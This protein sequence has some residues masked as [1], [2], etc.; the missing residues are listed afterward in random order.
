MSLFF[1]ITQSLDGFVAGP[2]PSRE[3]PLGKGGEA[4]HEWAFRLNAWK[5]PHGRGSDGAADTPEDAMVR[6]SQARAGAVIMGRLMFSGGSGPWADD[7]NANGWWGGEPP[8]GKPVFVL[9]HHERAP[10][11]LGATTFEFVTDG[12]EAALDRATA[13]AGD[14]DVQVSGGASVGRQYLAAG[15]L[16]ELLIH[17]APNMLGGGTRLL[18]GETAQLEIAETLEGPL[19]THV[20]YRVVR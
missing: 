4:L 20:R 1:E 14:K 10:L 6:G 2:A 16:D 19:A 8:F 12:I 7:T 17:T 5:E 18:E 9:T 13:A 3:D 15:L 11:M